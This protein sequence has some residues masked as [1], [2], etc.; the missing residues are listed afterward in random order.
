M[1]INENNNNDNNAIVRKHCY[2]TTRVLS[3]RVPSFSIIASAT[4]RVVT[5]NDV[6]VSRP[7]CIKEHVLV[8][9]I[10]L[11]FMSAAVS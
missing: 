11:R 9:G 4:G 1:R 10:S 7:F 2:T 5:T 3:V 6:S 8:Y